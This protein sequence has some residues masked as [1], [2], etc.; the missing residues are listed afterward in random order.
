MSAEPNT[1]PIKQG[2]NA[3]LA[4]STESDAT[5]SL[6]QKW[7]HDCITLDTACAS[8]RQ[9][10]VWDKKLPARLVNVNGED[11]STQSPR[12]VDTDE[13]PSNTSYLTLSHSWGDGKFLKLLSTNW[14]LL[15]S[16]IP[17]NE[18]SR[19]H[20]DAL[21]LT[22]RLGYQYIWIDSLCI[23]QDSSDDWKSQSTQMAS[24]YGNSTCNIAAENASRR[25]GCFIRRNALMQR[26]CQLTQSS[27]VDP[28]EGIYAHPYHTSNWSAFP[29][30][31]Y[32]SVP[33]LGRAWVQQERMLS[34]R[35]LY[36]GGSEIHWEC[37]SFQASEV[38]PQGSPS[39]DYGFDEVYP[40]KAAFGSLIKPF[41]NWD[42]EDWNVFVYELWHNGVIREYTAAELTFEKDRLVAL[43]GIAGVIQKRTGMTYVAG[44]WKELLPMDLM[45]QNMDPPVAGQKHLKPMPWKAPTWSWASVKGRKRHNLYAYNDPKNGDILYVSRVIDC[46]VTPLEI[47][48][49]ILGEVSGGTIT[50]TGFL[51]L[52]VRS[53]TA[54]TPKVVINFD[55]DVPFSTQL[56]Y[57][58]LMKT[59]DNETTR[60]NKGLILAKAEPKPEADSAKHTGNY[61]RVGA[62]VSSYKVETGCVFD[63]VEEVLINIC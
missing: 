38:W 16:S 19:T 41:K 42:R 13:F 6:A 29:N 26:P 27:D 12:V 17:V 15:Y 54:E 34:P 32:S 11:S 33:L 48:K 5:I 53:Q 7:L 57:F 47:D 60:T 37:C 59:K 52:L 30:H 51:A 24:I 10:A 4:L 40:L 43:A 62:F 63:N 56:F 50:L 31:Y 22:R 18:L 44:L 14:Q 39:K 35:I 3:Q 36:F 1:A 21:S 8:E 61:I 20:R 9:S 49:P 28:A 55:I 2:F 46:V 45:W 23:I 25:G 58:C